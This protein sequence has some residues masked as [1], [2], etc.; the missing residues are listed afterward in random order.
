MTELHP[1]HLKRELEELGGDLTA[2]LQE[3]PIA[4]VVLDAE[5]V[6]RWENAASEAARGDLIGM[7]FTEF[8]APGDLDQAQQ[9]FTRILCNGEPAEF[10]VHVREPGGGFSPV[11]V[12]SAPLRGNGSVVGVFG[13]ARRAAPPS[14]AAAARPAQRGG[15]GLTRRQLEV[16]RLL[17]EGMSTRDIAATLHLSPTTV[18]NHVATILATLGV[19]TRLQAVLTAKRNGLLEGC[20]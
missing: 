13:L 19:H 20:G 16:L 14:A 3:L 6:V 8:V 7:P 11:Q 4:A 5:G 9:V 12:S 10:T 15:E 18:R 2:A 1:N 17:G